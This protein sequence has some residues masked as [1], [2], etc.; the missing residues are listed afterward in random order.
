VPEHKN[1]D[2][3]AGAGS[4]SSPSKHHRIALPEHEPAVIDV[5]RDAMTARLPPAVEQR[6]Q[7]RLRTLDHNKETDA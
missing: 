2:A 6:I 3:P 7:Q 1:Q 5:V 4:A